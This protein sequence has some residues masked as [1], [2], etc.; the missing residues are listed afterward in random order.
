MRFSMNLI[1]VWNWMALPQPV[2]ANSI[3]V[4]DVWLLNEIYTRTQLSSTRSDNLISQNLFDVNPLMHQFLWQSRAMKIQRK[5]EKIT[6]T[7][8]LL[9]WKTYTSIMKKKRKKK[10][11]SAEQ[12]NKWQVTMC[13]GT[14]EIK[15]VF[16]IHKS[17]KYFAF[18]KH[19][20][21]VKWKSTSRSFKSYILINRKNELKTNKAII[22]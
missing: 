5:R 14:R 22:L 15:T 16:K 4:F 12:N 6:Q 20:F 9:R 13:I 10:N 3:H 2:K 1:E 21:E 8:R 11:K 7:N 19:H 17:P 18:F